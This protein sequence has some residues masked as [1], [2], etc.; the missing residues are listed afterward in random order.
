MFALLRV[1]FEALIRG[2]FLHYAASDKHWRLYKKDK[3]MTKTFGE[4]ITEVERKIDEQHQ[5]LTK[6]KKQSYKFL[7]SFTHT[8]YQHLVRRHSNGAMGAVGYPEREIIQLLNTS[9]TLSL[10]AFAGL[11]EISGDKKLADRYLKRAKRYSLATKN[12]A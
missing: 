4:M 9:G 5:V 7:C 6:F 1:Q 11:V 12:P 10:L 8:G 3:E 2:Q